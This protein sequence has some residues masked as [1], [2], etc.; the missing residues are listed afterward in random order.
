MSAAN[1]RG[2]AE[3]REISKT[4]SREIEFPESRI[5]NSHVARITSRCFFVFESGRGDRNRLASL[6]SAVTKRQFAHDAFVGVRPKH[7]VRPQ[8]PLTGIKNVSEWHS[9][10]QLGPGDHYSRTI[11]LF[12]LPASH[13][14][15]APLP[16]APPFGIYRSR[17]F[18]LVKRIINTYNGFLIPTSRSTTLFSRVTRP[19]EREKERERELLAEL[20][21]G[22]FFSSAP[23]LFVSLPHFT[24]AFCT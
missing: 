15:G 10:R 13:S 3:I 8:K 22:T 16:P 11:P 7:A 9:A 14:S 12:R 24:P 18:V 20:A 5:T 4:L 21:A 6:K 19:S 1:S 23:F 2:S 17:S